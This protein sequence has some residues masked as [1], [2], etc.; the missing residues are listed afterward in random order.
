V[1]ASVE[2]DAAEVIDN[3]F[4]E[5]IQRDPKLERHWV[6]LVDG[7]EAQL[8]AIRR[9]AREYGVEPTLILDFI[10]VLEYLW[11]AAWC[12][13]ETGDAAAEAWVAERARRI[14]HG[15][16]SLVA[17]GIR[18]SATKLGLEPEDRAAMDVCADYL[19]KYK[20]MMRYDEALRDGLPIATGVIEGA[21]RHLVKDRMDLTGARWSVSGAE[22]VLRLR[23]LRSS[24]DFDAYWD[25][26]RRAELERNHLT[27]YAAHELVALRD[28]A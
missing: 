19:L 10:H 9:T 8:R 22:A 1:W 14:L 24:G 20:A 11:D 6:V 17:A 23:A 2:K 15:H 27:H 3:A 12:L 13:Y 21:V 5:A 4:Y 7:N 18:R 26:H 16:A 25:F 28:A